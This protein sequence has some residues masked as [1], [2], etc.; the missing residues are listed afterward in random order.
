VQ[1]ALTDLAGIQSAKVDL[2][3]GEVLVRFDDG[4]VKPEAMAKA[5][6]E[7]GF[8]SEVKNPKN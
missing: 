1:S 4:K 7:S 5:V 8:E 6:T 2:K 3:A